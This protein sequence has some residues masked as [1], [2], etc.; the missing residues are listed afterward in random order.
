[1]SEVLPRWILTGSLPPLLQFSRSFEHYFAAGI[2]AA[3]LFK[4]KDT[5]NL[6][7]TARGAPEPGRARGA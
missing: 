7:Q 6:L 2:Q 5:I 1:M 4:Y 3:K